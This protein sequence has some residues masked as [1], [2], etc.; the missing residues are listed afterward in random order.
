METSSIPTSTTT[1]IFGRLDSNITTGSAMM[2]K[3]ISQAMKKDCSRHCNKVN[4]LDFHLSREI[5]E[6]INKTLILQHS[7]V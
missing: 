4:W 7:A 1:P 6:R 3:C 5:T 2:K